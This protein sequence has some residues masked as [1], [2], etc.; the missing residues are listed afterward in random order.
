MYACSKSREI[1]VETNVTSALIVRAKRIERISTTR[2]F[3]RG[4]LQL[5][6]KKHTLFNFSPQRVQRMTQRAETPCTKK[7]KWNLG[8]Q[9]VDVPTRGC[10]TYS[11]G[12][13]TQHEWWTYIGK[14]RGETVHPGQ[15]GSCCP[16]LMGQKKSHQNMGLFFDP[17]NRT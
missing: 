4:A 13:N 7:I 12:R 11:A 14:I 3:F 16:I 2:S 5:E 8:R 10:K 1:S 6:R 9:S 17:K 15:D